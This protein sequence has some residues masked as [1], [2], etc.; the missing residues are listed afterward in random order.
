MTCR[1]VE[2]PQKSQVIDVHVQRTTME[3]KRILSF[4]GISHVMQL[5][6][7]GIYIID[8]KSD[9]LFTH[10]HDVTIKLRAKY[11]K[12]FHNMH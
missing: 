8:H 11:I 3:K 12:K 1:K 7:K 10:R 6:Y 2:T 5:Y 9:A 4:S